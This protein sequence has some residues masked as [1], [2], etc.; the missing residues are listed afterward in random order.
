MYFSIVAKKLQ[1]QA[2]LTI[3][4]AEIELIECTSK[5]VVTDFQE[6]QKYKTQVVKIWQM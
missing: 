3:N 4:L 2:A 6:D 1:Y 5:N